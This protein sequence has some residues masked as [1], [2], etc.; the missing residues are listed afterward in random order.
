MAH[1]F[2]ALKEMD[3]DLFAEYFCANVPTCCLVYDHRGFGDS[4]AAPGHPH[5]EI[6]PADQ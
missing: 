2:T 4:D 5:Q 1:G 6:I 3:L